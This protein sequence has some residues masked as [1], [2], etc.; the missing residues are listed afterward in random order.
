MNY[1]FIHVYLKRKKKE[2]NRD[3]QRLKRKVKDFVNKRVFCSY[4][5][6]LNNLIRINLLNDIICLLIS[7]FI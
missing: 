2:V 7:Q 1:V 3:E 4:L 6:T 5:E